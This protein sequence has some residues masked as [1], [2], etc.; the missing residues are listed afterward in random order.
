MDISQWTVDR[1]NGNTEGTVTTTIEDYYHSMV[2]SIGIV[3]A[4]VSRSAT[5][6]EVMTNQLQEIR[7]SIS[8][9]SLDEEMTN[10]MKFQHAYTAAA[11]L[12]SI[13]DEMLD[14]LVNMT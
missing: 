10:L 3:S 7:D 12:I 1:I 6:N 14:T 5:F 11:K 8:A 4:G 13:S 2:A 9:V